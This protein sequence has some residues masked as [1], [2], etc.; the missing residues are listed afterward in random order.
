MFEQNER[1]K[2]EKRFNTQ[3]EEM[4]RED[5]LLLYKLRRMQKGIERKVEWTEEAAMKGHT[6]ITGI[7]IFFE[8]G[9]KLSQKY[10]KE[11][12]RRIDEEIGEPPSYRTRIRD[13][14][15]VPDRET[16][17]KGYRI[18]RDKD[19]PSKTKEISF[20]ILN[21]TLWTRNKAFKAG[22]EEEMREEQFLI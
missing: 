16:Y 8:E 19:V 9:G 2:L 7:K 20:Q 6:E 11:I 14:I 3:I 12:R 10:S 21:R 15:I 5:Q 13:R 1:G 18:V 17:S 22:I 4:L